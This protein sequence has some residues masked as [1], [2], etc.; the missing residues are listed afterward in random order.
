MFFP[1]IYMLTI[2]IFSAILY[3]VSVKFLKMRKDDIEVVVGSL[4]ISIFWPL[5][6][7]ATLVVLPSLLAYQYIN[8]KSTNV[9]K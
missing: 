4:L 1:F 3:I 7:T 5:V 2:S 6:L 9:E 8:R